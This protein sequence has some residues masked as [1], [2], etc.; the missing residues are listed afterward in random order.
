MN[1]LTYIFYG[2]RKIFN[3]AYRWRLRTES[4]RCTRS[5]SPLHKPA[6]SQRLIIVLYSYKQRNDNI[7]IIGTGGLAKE[8][9]GFIE[10]ENT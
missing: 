6:T 4:N 5:C 10:S 8:L 3:E 7:H 1:R 9:I 2:R